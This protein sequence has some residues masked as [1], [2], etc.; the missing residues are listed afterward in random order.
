MMRRERDQ[1]LRS[2]RGGDADALGELLRHHAPELR[3]HVEGR[4]SRRWVP[5]LSADDVL[6]ETFADAFLAIRTADLTGDAP[7]LAWLRKLGD[8]NLVDVVRALRAEK[9]GG[10]SRR[11][12][13]AAGAD[14][15]DALQ[16]HIVGA[17][18][19]RTPSRHVRRDEACQ[20]LHPTLRRLPETHRQVIELYDLQGW[21]MARVAAVLGRSVGAAHLLRVRAHR[22]LR[23]FLSGKSTILRDL[24]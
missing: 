18:P 19:T 10:T 6:Q 15:F 21:P 3:R 8:N 16:E 22:R 7:F 14:L 12:G 4:I 11:V 24:S 2:A 13:P 9:R 17:R 23:E 20:T 1:L 5:L